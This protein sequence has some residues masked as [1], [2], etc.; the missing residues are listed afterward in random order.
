MTVSE[1]NENWNAHLWS[2]SFSLLTMTLS[3]KTMHPFT[4][5]DILCLVVCSIRL[6]YMAEILFNEVSLYPTCFV[7]KTHR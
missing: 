6:N 2:W 1:A 7:L 4:Y 3:S 5:S